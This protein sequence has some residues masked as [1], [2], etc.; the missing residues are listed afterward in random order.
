MAS[1][2]CDGGTGQWTS[3]FSFLHDIAGL[4]GDRGFMLRP[5]DSL[6]SIALLVLVLSDVFLLWSGDLVP[7]VGGPL[8][9]R[10]LCF[11]LVRWLFLIYSG[12]MFTKE[13]CRFVL[14]AMNLRW[15][16]MCSDQVVLAL[17]WWKV[18][19]YL[20]WATKWTL[21]IFLI[22][23]GDLITVAV[24][25]SSL[26]SRWSIIQWLSLLHWE[27]R[28]KCFLGSEVTVTIDFLWSMITIFCCGCG[29]FKLSNRWM[30]M[31]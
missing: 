25:T 13:S 24:C 11:D 5:C 9:K 14:I 4:S 19:V 10:K 22:N 27:W 16:L 28:L 18:V 6:V 31:I 23:S 29:G 17:S 21:L 2:Q 30:D 26:I 7:R 3:P 8:F 20:F 15:L 12:H 1:F